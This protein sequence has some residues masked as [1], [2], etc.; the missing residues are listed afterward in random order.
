[1]AHNSAIPRS[2]T[3]RIHLLQGQFR[4][5]DDPNVEFATVLGSCIAACLFDP[6]AR[7]GGMNHF[8][9]AEP[10]AN[11][12]DGEINKEHGSY[13]MEALVNEMLAA[14][15]SRRQLRA[16]LY[17]GANLLAGMAWIG[18]ANAEFARAFLAEQNIALSYV[19]T[20]GAKARQVDFR[21]ALGKVRCQ[22]I[23]SLAGP[24]LPLESLS[25]HTRDAADTFCQK[26]E[27]R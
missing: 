4:V 11:K 22:A 17:G 26:R 15:A 21:P 24:D 23:K 13:L 16:H 9:L 25:P 2:P 12:S 5:S 1:M 7:L 18:A 10:L 3:R 14:G 6:E 19:D 8:V 20:G 27:P